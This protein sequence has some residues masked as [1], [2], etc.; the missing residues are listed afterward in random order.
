MHFESKEN[1]FD[2]KLRSKKLFFNSSIFNKLYKKC[3]E[4]KGRIY[5]QA[6]TSFQG[7]LIYSF[8]FPAPENNKS[9]GKTTITFLDRG[10]NE[11][12]K[13]Y[14][15]LEIKSNQFCYE[16]PIPLFSFSTYLHD[17]EVE[18]EVSR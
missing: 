6:P 17:S 9:K 18:K 11:R 16:R 7:I 2:M 5:T 8:V 15:I 13:R 10:F 12:M 14:I 3:E 1:N 4:E